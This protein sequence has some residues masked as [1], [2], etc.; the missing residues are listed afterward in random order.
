MAVAVSG[1]WGQLP[2]HFSWNDLQVSK[3]GEIV[4]RLAPTAT[5]S[6]RSTNVSQFPSFQSCFVQLLNWWGIDNRVDSVQ[7]FSN[8]ENVQLLLTELTCQRHRTTVAVVPEMI[9]TEPLRQASS[10]T[11]ELKVLQSTS[12]HASDTRATEDI[13]TDILATVAQPSE[14][15]R[16]EAYAACDSASVESRPPLNV[17][18]KSHFVLLATSAAAVLIVGLASWWWF[19]SGDGSM[20]IADSTSSNSTSSNST[21]SSQPASDVSGSN[22]RTAS[23]PAVARRDHQSRSDRRLPKWINCS[24]ERPQTTSAIRTTLIR[25]VL[26][27]QA[28]QPWANCRVER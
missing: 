11:E 23:L 10:V 21:R 3:Q 13:A 6:R 19:S 9:A 14:D 22:P 27:R 7:L 24:A 17:C 25:S 20:R 15:H 16:L 1:S 8:W 12:V 4:P 26:L 2:E 28:M 5:T 18:S